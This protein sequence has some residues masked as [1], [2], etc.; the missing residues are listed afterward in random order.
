MTTPDELIAI[1]SRLLD[2][3]REEKDIEQFE[4]WTKT[5]D[6]QTVVQLVIQLGK[7]NTNIGEGQ[8]IEIGDRLDTEL[9]K[10]IRD[11]LRSQQASQ[12]SVSSSASVLDIDWHTISRNFLTEHRHLTTNQI[13]A[14]RDMHRE[15]DE[16]Y[17]SLALVERRKPERQS[18]QARLWQDTSLSEPEYEEKQRF[19]HQQFLQDVLR[20]GKGKSQGTRI[21]MIGEPG[22]GKTTLLCKIAFWLAQSSE[23]IPI[24][25]SLA[26]LQEQSLEDY[27]L[28]KWLKDALKVVR[29]MPEQ[30]EVLRSLFEQGR[31]WLLLDGADEMT[32]G[33]YQRSP[34]QTIH[35]ELTGWVGQA[36]VILT[37]RLNLWDTMPNALLNQFEI[38]RTLPF[39]YGDGKTS[40]QVGEFI[41]KWFKGEQLGQ[42]LHQALEQPG[43]ERIKDLAKNPLRLALLCRTWHLWREQGGLPDTK[44]KLYQGF[45]DDFYNFYESRPNKPHVK[46]QQRRKLN[47][48]LGKLAKWALD[49]PTARFRLRLSQIPEPLAQILGDEDE[50]GS[51]LWW[52]VSE[53]NW[54]VNIG[55]SAESPGDAVY[56]F[57]HP[58][59]QEYFGA[60]AI[61]DWHFFL[62]HIPENPMHPDASYRI[63]E[64]QWEEV[65]ILWFGLDKDD[66]LTAQKDEFI[67][68]LL[69]FNDKCLNLYG[70]RAYFLG[71]NA[72]D[73]FQESI[74]AKDIASIMDAPIDEVDNNVGQKLAVAWNNLIPGLD[75]VFVKIS[76]PLE[77]TKYFI[78]LLKYLGFNLDGWKMRQI[79]K[80]HNP[81]N[82]ISFINENCVGSEN[83]V[84]WGSTENIESLLNL[85]ATSQERDI[86][87]AALVKILQ[88][89][90]DN[91]ASVVVK[92]SESLY[93][94][95]YKNICHLL[96]WILEYFNAKTIEDI[97]AILTLLFECDYEPVRIDI[98]DKITILDN[99]DILKYVVSQLKNKL[100]SISNEP[101]LKVLAQHLDKIISHCTRIL[102]YASFYQS[103]NA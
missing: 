99:P 21:A 39:S 28:Q 91:P 78:N 23:D 55:D 38:Y 10:E 43:K 85:L 2:G 81:Q 14:D 56:T 19:E 32:T 35:S 57:F 63:F 102:P 11:L 29:V 71:V 8:G 61:D 50:E 46:K 15:L 37:C 25:I 16:M 59:F 95:S 30:E 31:V 33:A 96:R 70:Y 22:A 34:L 48:A 44:A 97:D 20:A 47:E 86:R 54:L 67:K 45:V 73:E 24:L 88:D 90:I 7:Y 4:N 9:L 3:S 62:N 76:L 52:L 58:T 53:L 83:E 60:L 77:E 5:G 74:Y 80:L 75:N 64:P 65:V 49:Q 68:L 36:R 100:P 40:D 94:S 69:E 26:D 82:L 72:I 6:A 103:W 27:L 98:C 79:Q 93:T 92:L 17:V 18:E 84:F 13:V 42:E 87:R 51:L 12:S 41:T 89:A 66:S 101:R 1:L